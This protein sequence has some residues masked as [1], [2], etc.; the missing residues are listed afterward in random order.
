MRFEDHEGVL[1]LR[2]EGGKANSLDAEFLRLLDDALDEFDRRKGSALVYTGYDRFFSA[3]LAIPSLLPLNRDE[4]AAFMLDFRAV[5]LRLFS[6]PCPTVAAING[7]AIA[8]GFVL[9]MQADHRVATKAPCKLGLNETRL[10]VGLPPVVVETMRSQ[11]PPTSLFSACAEGSLHDTQTMLDLGLVHELVPNDEVVSRSL[12]L[13]ARY[14]AIPGP[15][16]RQVKALLRDPVMERMSDAS[17][18]LER[19]RDCWFDETTQAGLQ[20]IAAGL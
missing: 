17:A 15:A 20:A 11:A 1:L 6:L 18:G 5:V 3:G 10:G 4:M 7:H 9:A 13:A 12:A 16:L 8:G 2:M 14:A 19:W